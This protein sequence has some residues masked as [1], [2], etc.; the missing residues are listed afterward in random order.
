MTRR[1]PLFA[2]VCLALIAT[3][4][5]PAPV[6]K[7]TNRDGRF[8]TMKTSLG[9]I[10]IEL[11]EDKAPITVK[12]FLAYVDAKHYDGTVFHRVIPK[13]MAQGGGYEKGLAQVNT[14]QGIK[15]REKKTNPA[16][17]NESANG[18]PNKRG[19][20]AMARTAVS[21]SATAQFFINVKDNVFL[22]KSN[23]SDGYCVFG[24]V[25]AGM[26]VVDK[27]EAVKTKSVAGFNDVP[28]EDVVI[29]SVRRGK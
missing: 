3:A 21:D 19:T 15:A 1:V 4:F 22:D 24:R 8:V 5:A 20:L 17:K 16:I 25:V 29:E 26:D 6:P 10:T 14:P 11:F 23:S 2:L 9:T 12:N 28:V 13:F 27:L 7:E 18:P